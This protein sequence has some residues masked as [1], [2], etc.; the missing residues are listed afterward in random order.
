M[1][2]RFCAWCS[3]ATGGGDLCETC[4]LGLEK[5]PEQNPP[6]VEAYV[7]RGMRQLEHILACHAGFQRWLRD[8]DK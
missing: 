4:L 5:Y 2:P 3:K 1:Q 8:H 7:G 6:I